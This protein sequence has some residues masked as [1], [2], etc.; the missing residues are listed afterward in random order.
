MEDLLP[1]LGCM[2]FGAIGWVAAR[3]WTHLT[4]HLNMEHIKRQE[5]ERGETDGFKLGYQAGLSSPFRRRLVDGSE[6]Y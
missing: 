6:D 1:V 3:I 4:W 2:I 5:W